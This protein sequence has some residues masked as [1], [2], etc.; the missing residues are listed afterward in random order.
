MVTVLEKEI[1]EIVEGSIEVKAV[2]REPGVRAKVAVKTN[3]SR[4]DAVGAC[5][6]IR[7]ARVQ[8]VSGVLNGERV[9]VLEWSDDLVELVINAFSPVEVLT[10]ELDEEKQVMNI[11]V[12]QEQLS[13]AIGRSGQN[14]RLVSDLLGWV[15]NVMSVES[16]KEKAE[17][18]ESSQLAVLVDGLGVDEG[19]AS[20]LVR[21]GFAVLKSLPTLI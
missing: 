11:A 6:G 16:M 7:G 2:A 1:P 5:V 9:D 12:S 8:T 18:S 10:V 17:T 19:I 14:V 3:D 15:V 4:I 13:Q 20:I 21:E